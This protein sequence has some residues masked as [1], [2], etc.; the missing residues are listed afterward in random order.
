MSAGKPAYS[1]GYIRAWRR[2]KL[3]GETGDRIQARATPAP[4]RLEAGRVIL[5]CRRGDDGDDDDDDDGDGDG[6]GKPLLPNLSRTTLRRMLPPAPRG[7]SQIVSVSIDCL[8]HADPSN[9]AFVSFTGAFC[10]NILHVLVSRVVWLR[11]LRQTELRTSG[12]T[13]R[14]LC[15]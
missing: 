2:A 1:G 4:A 9:A 5:L 13:S 14:F 11:T 10:A 6:S 15:T 8:P 7:L 12:A 3:L